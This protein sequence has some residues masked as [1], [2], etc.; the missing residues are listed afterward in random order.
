MQKDNTETLSEDEV[1]MEKE[2]E[3]KLMSFE[4]VLENVRDIKKNS[5]QNIQ[6]KWK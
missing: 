4:D 6:H 5:V 2:N 1:E 3:T